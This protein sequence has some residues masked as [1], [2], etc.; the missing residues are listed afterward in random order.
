MKDEIIDYVI[1]VLGISV[2]PNKIF[3][4]IKKISRYAGPGCV[5]DVFNMLNNND[6]IIKRYFI[7]TNLNNKQ[8]LCN[9]AYVIEN[10][11]FKDNKIKKQLE[12]YL[13]NII[14][15]M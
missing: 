11:F 6:I 1:L 10:C 12:D 3:K 13:Y 2:I 8:S 4:E 5:S 15:E 14:R 7:E 9:L